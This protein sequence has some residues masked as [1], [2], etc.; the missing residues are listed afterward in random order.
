MTETKLTPY[1]T[2]DALEPKPWPFESGNQYGLVDFDDEESRTVFTV[3]G[4]PQDQGADFLLCISTYTDAPSIEVDGDRA[5]VLTE[6]I[7]A[8]IRELKEFAQIGY[9]G[10][11]DQ[12]GVDAG[13]TRAHATEATRRWALAELSLTALHPTT[14]KNNKKETRS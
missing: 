3:L 14:A 2:G 12:M 8:G 10:L 7:L 11:L 6:E 13:I 1:D 9:H 4:K 5:V